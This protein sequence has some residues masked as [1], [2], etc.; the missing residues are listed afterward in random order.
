MRLNVTLI[1][2]TGQRCAHLSSDQ[3]TI[4]SLSRVHSGHFAIEMTEKKCPSYLELNLIIFAVRTSIQYHEVKY[5]NTLTYWFFLLFTNS[6]ELCGKSFRCDCVCISCGCENLLWAAEELLRCLCEEADLCDRVLYR[7]GD[8]S[9]R[10]ASVYWDPKRA[11][12]S[13]RTEITQLTE[14]MS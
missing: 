5:C 10:A 1:H 4:I 6:T 11:V 12:M 9:G 13:R 14:N 2:W 8:S 7:H 3:T